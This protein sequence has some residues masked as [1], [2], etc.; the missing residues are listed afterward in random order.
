MTDTQKGIANL[1]W[2]PFS[3][4]L[5]LHAYFTIKYLNAIEITLNLL[6]HSTNIY[7]YTMDL[8]INRV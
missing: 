2:P 5:C 3:K 8:S 7:S 6:I 4:K 1:T